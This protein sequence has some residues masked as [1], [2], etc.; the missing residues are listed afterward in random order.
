LLRK[1]LQ[2]AMAENIVSGMRRITIKDVAK[3]AGVSPSAVSRVL[4]AGGS[5]SADTRTKVLAATERLGYR[6]SLLARGLTGNRTQLVTLVAGEMTNPFDALFLEQFANALAARGM[7]LLLI[8]AGGGE[9]SGEALLEALDYRSDAVIAAAGTMTSEH[10][11]LCVR[12]GLPVVLSGRVLEARGVDC[13]L[14]DNL[15]GARL[16]AELL[17]RSGCRRLAYLGLDR[18]TFADRERSDG[19]ADAAK[20]VPVSVHRAAGSSEAEAFAAATEMLSADPRPDGIFC[21]NDSLAIAAIEAARTLHLKIPDDVAIVGFNDIAMAGW[22]SF[23]LTTIAYSVSQLVA[24]IVVLLES[25][26]ADPSRPDIVQRIPVRLIP[27][28]TT[29]RIP[30]SLME[31]P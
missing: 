12:A 4:T 2:T 16:A 3:A 22:P 8:P 31:T 5:A 17:L 11:E 21:S 14:A 10:S 27:R 29:R 1:R 19:F 28:A 13:V 24:A 23:Q 20:A 26:L 25:R 18:S 30:P 6:P 15:G 9:Q 7:R